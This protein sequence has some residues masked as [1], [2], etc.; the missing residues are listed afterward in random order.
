M[1]QQ[2]SDHAKL[3]T[4]VDPSARTACGIPRSNVLPRAVRDSLFA[5]GILFATLFS[6]GLAAATKVFLGMGA[7]EVSGLEGTYQTVFEIWGASDNFDVSLVK[8]NVDGSPFQIDIID[9]SADGNLGAGLLTPCEDGVCQCSLEYTPETNRVG[10][11]CSNSKH[12]EYGPMRLEFQVVDGES[13]SPA[14]RATGEPISASNSVSNSVNNAVRNGAGWL[15]FTNQ[16]INCAASGC[17]SSGP[18]CDTQTVR[19]QCSFSRERAIELCAGHPECRAVTCNSQRD[20]CQARSVTRLDVWEG[21]TSYTPSQLAVDR[22]SAANGGL[23]P[24]VKN[25]AVQNTQQLV[26]G[27]HYRGR[28][29]SPDIGVVDTSYE[30]FSD[31][32]Y[33]RLLRTSV[34]G[35]LVEITVDKI[36]GR[37]NQYTGQLTP[38]EDGV[39]RCKIS[40]DESVL[41]GSCSNSAHPEY[42]RADF[43]MW[44]SD[45]PPAQQFSVMASG[46]G[47]IVSPEGRIETNFEI[48]GD[49]EQARLIKFMDPN[50]VAFEISVAENNDGGTEGKGQLSPCEGGDC[51]CSMSE[52]DYGILGVCSNTAR[53]DHGELQFSVW[54]NGRPSSSVAAVVPPP[55]RQVPLSVTQPQAV[56]PKVP[57][58]VRLSL[59]SNTVITRTSYFQKTYNGPGEV[60]PPIYVEVTFSD[61]S[62]TGP[63][64]HHDEKFADKVIFDDVT[65]DPNDVIHVS[66]WDRNKKLPASKTP[67]PGRYASQ[68]SAPGYATGYAT[69]KVRLRDAPGIS[70]SV[71]VTVVGAPAPRTTPA[72]VVQRP[73]PRQAPPVVTQP[74]RSQPKV[75][76]AIKLW[77]RTNTVI[78]GQS[79]AQKSYAGPGEGSPPIYMTVTFSDGSTMGPFEYQKRFHQNVIFDDTSGDPDD[80]IKVSYWNVSDNGDSSYVSG[81]GKFAAQLKAPGNKTGRATLKVSLRNA[82]GIVAS[83][84]ITVVGAPPLRAE[85]EP[86]LMGRGRGDF[87][88]AES[89]FLI[90]GLGDKAMHIDINTNQNAHHSFH[91]DQ[92]SYGQDEL[93]GSLSPCGGGECTCTLF[94]EGQDYFIGSCPAGSSNSNVSFRFRL[95]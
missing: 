54:L 70:D 84:P 26:P 76:V 15:M 20:D 24:S 90:W 59:R 73:P 81:P 36:D 67:G 93:G 80:L 71:A 63:Y 28:I 19:D 72:P 77:L 31:G 95:E 56:Q 14:T 89:E 39:C 74:Q 30:T 57:V 38:C 5:I 2:S 94:E 10:G 65:G 87:N 58:S 79:Y 85:P 40:G 4:I 60:D 64:D 50:N 43:A 33:I 34:D 51:P 55:T 8:F 41:A 32:E 35:Q 69:L 29:S 48:R 23:P 68:L 52:V 83:V 37:G 45:R 47:E 82:P 92:N 78:N 17:I 61:G 13:G 25:V 3:I 49:G 7:G 16:A 66:Y 1:N 62:K 22:R 86:F 44:F 42:G 88:G 27:Q 12:P 53:P 18:G 75:P 11:S 46:P 91:I 6:P 21:F 9:D